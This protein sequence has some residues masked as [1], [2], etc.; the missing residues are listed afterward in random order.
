MENT[1]EQ[2]SPI[3]RREIAYYRRRQQN[4]VFS[5]LAKFFA[6][7]AESGRTTRKKIAQ[8]LGKDP[9]QITRWLSS[10]SNFELDTISDLLLAMGAEL[11]HRAIRFVDRSKPNFA[12]PLSIATSSGSPNVLRLMTFENKPKHPPRAG[13]AVKIQAENAA[14]TTQPVLSKVTLDASV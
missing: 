14:S 7:E 3:S 1:S 9:A 8:R 12:H 5:E 10:P 6:N 2:I 4:R 11:D 13:G